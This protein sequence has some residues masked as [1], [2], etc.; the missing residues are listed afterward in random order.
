M[1][2]PKARPGP[3]ERLSALAGL[4]DPACERRRQEMRAAWRGI[5]DDVDLGRM[6][7]AAAHRVEGEAPDRNT[8]HGLR[9]ED[10]K[11]RIVDAI[12]VVNGRD[13]FFLGRALCSVANFHDW[14]DR[15]EAELAAI[16]RRIAGEQHA[17]D[18]DAPL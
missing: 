8:A 11:A 17:P 5:D 18:V 10:A 3:A 15:R 4:L 13:L 14:P 9:I 2:R 6:E 1:K 12:P 16:E 7:L